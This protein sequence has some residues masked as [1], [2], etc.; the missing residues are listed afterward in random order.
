M[1]KYVYLFFLFISLSFQAFSQTTIKGAL[2][3]TVAGSK[4]PRAAI[5]LIDYKDS[6]LIKFTRTNAEGVFNLS[7]IPQGKYVIL[8][9]HP[10]YAGYSDYFDVTGQ[11]EMDLGNIQ[12]LS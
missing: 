8:I 4:I 10:M 6:S 2:V 5:T 3:D 1:K 11:P 9:S 12:L 7:G